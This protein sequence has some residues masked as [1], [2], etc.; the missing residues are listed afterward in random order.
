[1]TLIAFASYNDHAEILTDTFSY[2]GSL[3][4]TG[5]TTKHITLNHLDAA[6][7]TTGDAGFTDRARLYA[8]QAAALVKDF[9]E[10]VAT[11]S[12][13]VRSLWESLH[14]R[15]IDDPDDWSTLCLVGWSNRVAEGL[16]ETGC[17]RC[18]VLG[19]EDGF[20]PQEAPGLWMSPT[21]WTH[22]PSKLEAD[23]LTRWGLEYD[24][25]RD[26]I[27]EVVADWQAKPLVNKPW[28][29]EDWVH[30][31]QMAREQRALNSFGRIF[32]AGQLI[33]T[34]L[35][36]GTVT[37]QVVHTFDDTGEEFAEMVRHTS[38]PLGQVQPC[39]CGSGRRFID[40]HLADSLTEPCGCRSGQEFGNC[41]AVVQRH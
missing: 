13:W 18:Y 30:L 3:E 35:E 28:N 41:C 37:S 15:T 29:I 23:R 26:T 31:G 9:D 20:A 14:G 24:T 11:S 38:H 5:Q 10:L 32:I 33:H 25:T 7:L 22:R 36:R 6:V 16:P 2:V 40:C 21:P 8:L 4:Q 27:R 39:W 19:P 12:E 17:F 1:M 34:R